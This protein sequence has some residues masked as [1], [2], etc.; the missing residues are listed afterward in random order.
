MTASLPFTVSSGALAICCPTTVVRLPFA[1][2]CAAVSKKE[3]GQSLI[4]PSCVEFKGTLMFV[5]PQ[6]EGSLDQYRRCVEHDIEGVI[7]A[8]VTE[9]GASGRRSSRVQP[10]DVPNEHDRKRRH[11][12]QSNNAEDE[13][14]V[15]DC[16]GTAPGFRRGTGP[17]V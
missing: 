6:S 10:L 15:S 3:S 2:V 1:C 7:S 4:T 12:D 9:M 11:A 5:G 8:P 14:D 13:C 17:H 16:V